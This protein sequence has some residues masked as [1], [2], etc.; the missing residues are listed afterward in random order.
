MHV[1]ALVAGLVMMTPLA[2]VHLIVL[3]GVKF[4]IDSFY[5]GLLSTSQFGTTVAAWIIK[6]HSTEGI[7]NLNVNLT[8]FSLEPADRMR[9]GLRRCQEGI[10]TT[11]HGAAGPGGYGS[12]RKANP[13]EY[14][15]KFRSDVCSTGSISIGRAWIG[16]T[17]VI[18][19]IIVVIVSLIE[20]VSQSSER[21]NQESRVRSDFLFSSTLLF[22]TRSSISFNMSV[23][24]ITSSA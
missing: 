3:L 19:S 22:S 18:F 9:K 15:L 10:L 12:R 6:N 1:L 16:K 11:F 13:S 17:S 24:V 14:S 7:A 2:T 8:V 4:A 5:G 23:S 20:F 21:R